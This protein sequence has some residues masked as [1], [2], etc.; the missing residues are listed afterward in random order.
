MALSGDYFL[1][2]VPSFRLKS[3]GVMFIEV[4]FSWLQRPLFVPRCSSKAFSQTG[5]AELAQGFPYRIRLLHTYA[6]LA[7]VPYPS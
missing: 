7:E 1:L 4:I 3:V 5:V 2:A 6:G